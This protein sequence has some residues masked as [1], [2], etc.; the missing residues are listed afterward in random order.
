MGEPGARVSKAA[1]SVEKAADMKATREAFATLSDAVV[2]AAKADGW[3]D[4]SGLKL[5]YC[6]MVKHSWLQKGETMQNPVLR[7]VHAGLRRIQQD[8]VSVRRRIQHH[9]ATAH[10]C[11]ARQRP[12]RPGSRGSRLSDRRGQH[13]VPRRIEEREAGAHGLRAPVRASDVRGVRA[14]T[15]R[16]TSIRFRRRAARSTARPT[17]TA[18]TTGKSCRPTRL[19]LALWMESDRMGYLL[20]A[21]TEQK[22]QNQRDVVLNERRQNYE[23]RP[24]GF[25]GMAMVAA[26]YP[27]DHPY[28]W[29]T[30]GE[31]A[32]LRAAELDDVRAFFQTYYRPRN[33]SHC[34]RRV[35]SIPMP[36]DRAGRATT[37]DRSRRA[38]RRRLSRPC[39]SGGAGA[40][41][42]AGAR[43]SR[44]AAAALS[45]LAFGRPVRRRR[46]RDGSRS[47]RS[48]PAA[49]P[50]GS[51][52]R[53][54]TTSAS[55][56]RSPRRRTRARLAAS[57]RSSPPRRPGGHSRSSRRR[58]PARST[59]S[60]SE[61]PT[62]DEMER[63]LAQAESHFIY[64]CRPSADSA[65]SRIS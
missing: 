54:S 11:D 30:I 39:A 17:P 3:T 34:A 53:W 8:E 51:I 58:S 9:A 5:A 10:P 27:P 46:R 14:L 25:A 31:P 33:A 15:T 50:R 26:L 42:P 61:G 49:R 29:L 16:A 2:A 45:R 1:A 12:R 13:L 47:R 44:R 64:G 57:S 55:P 35:T 23:N 36:R 19:E 4:V 22:F 38:I 7:P 28:H 63:C 43:G 24:Y 40:G 32:D 65:A 48:S 52:A 62:L 20:P 41:D 18:R 56:P 6:P 21:L 59:G 60:S 37:S